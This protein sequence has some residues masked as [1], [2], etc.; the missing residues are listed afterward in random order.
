MY[1]LFLNIIFLASP[2]QCI[3]MCIVPIEG[4]QVSSSIVPPPSS[5]IMPPLS[6]SI[7]PP[8]SSSIAPPPLS[9]VMEVPSVTEVPSVVEVPSVTEQHRGD[10]LLLHWGQISI[11]HQGSRQPISLEMQLLLHPISVRSPSNGSGWLTSPP[12]GRR[13]RG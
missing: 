11:M 12:V 1:L 13:V 10:D 3:V 7:T 6:S 5:S 4:Q 9:S 8:P 2:P